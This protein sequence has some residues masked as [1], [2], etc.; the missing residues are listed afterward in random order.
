LPGFFVGRY[1]EKMLLYGNYV[2]TRRTMLCL[3]ETLPFVTQKIAI[4]Y[5]LMTNNM[6]GFAF[7][8]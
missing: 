4:H 7:H 2:L 5:S 3:G 1:K 6:V 8:P